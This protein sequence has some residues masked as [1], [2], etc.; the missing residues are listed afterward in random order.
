MSGHRIVLAAP[1]ADAVVQ[2]ATREFDSVL[3]QDH[4]LTV[5][6]LLAAV[7]AH[8][9]QGVL[10]SSRVKLDA[11]AIGALSR[12]VR[13]L[14]T[15]SVGYDH[16]DVGAAA[17][18]GV[19]V[20][21]TPDVLT[22]ATADLT[23]MLLL[24]ACRRAAEGYALMQAGWGR[25]LEPNEMLGIEVSG[26]TLG[27]LGMGRIGQAV[28]AR[29]R[30]FGMRIRYHNRHRIPSARERG[31][32]YHASFRGMLPHCAFLS[33]HVPSGTGADNILD[34]DAIA[35]LPKGAVVIN[36]AR[37]QLVDEG[38]LIE[39]LVSGHLGAAGFDVFRTEPDYDLRLRDLPNVF[40]TPHMG[41]A[42]VETR[43]AMGLRALDNI[44]AVLSSRPPI[45]QVPAPGTRGP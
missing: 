25:R 24:C 5:D 31:A 15:C 34:R 3:S 11:V 44:A 30:G 36:A 2:R 23:M 16:I 10:A 32:T 35:L 42:T 29:A 40:L 12:T 39:A 38:A 26:K 7:V 4:T 13:V 21:N 17:K 9:A 1:F 22:A 14:A 6:E 19:V 27:I 28:A 45:D 41:S 18:F 20:T 33:L 43:N 8:Q 37:G